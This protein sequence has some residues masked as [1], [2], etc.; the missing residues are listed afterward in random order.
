MVSP[1]ILYEDKDVLVINKPAGIMVHGDG[2]TK[3]KTI[4]DWIL[5]TRPEMKGIGEPARF[6]EKEGKVKT[7]ERPGIVHRLDKDTTG[8][9]VIAKNTHAY[10]FLKKQFRERSIKKTYIAIVHGTVKS[11]RGVIDRPIGRSSADFRKR[12]A[13][14]GAKGDLRQA[15]TTYKTVRRF[16][17]KVKGEVKKYSLLLL[18][19]KTGRTHQIRVHLKAIGHPIV[20]DN[21]YAGKLGGGLSFERPALHAQSINFSIPSGERITVEALM[22]ADFNTAIKAVA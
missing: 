18:F 16:E 1:K 12:S 10:R 11:E 13:S 7:I 5:K 8:V 9:L 6:H 4:S 14:R 3:D 19:P 15:V 22:P 2:R 21:L 20:C 17:D